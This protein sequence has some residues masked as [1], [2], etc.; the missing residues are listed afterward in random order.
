[1]NI[2]DKLRILAKLNTASNQISEGIKMKNTTKVIAAILAA[3][4]GI[5]QIPVVQSALIAFVQA[6]PALS[7]G[8]GGISALLALL[9]VPIKGQAS[10][11]G[12]G[13]S[14]IAPLLILGLLAAPTHAQTA[15]AAPTAAPTAPV[16]FT[17]SSE[18]VAFRYNGNWS[19]GTTVTESFDFLDLGAAKSNRLFIAGKQILA[20]GPGLNM[21]LGDVIFQPDLSK[22]LNKTNVA[23][24]SFS[25]RFEGGLGVGLPSV[26]A[27]EIAWEAGGGVSYEMTTTLAW[28]SLN[29]FYGRVGSQSFAGLS[30]GLAYF[31]GK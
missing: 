17:G 2:I 30:T 1:M 24:G 29:A 10:T 5:V 18:A 12:S 23:P 27:S 11:S 19:A 15:T 28:Q 7:L 9:H 4:T 14:I 21:Y 26:G 3:L 8:L 6:H 16:G 20:P 25:A 22:V 31:F 13:V